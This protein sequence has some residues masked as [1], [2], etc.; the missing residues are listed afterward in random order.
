[1]KSS[2]SLKQGKCVALFIQV[3][4]THVDWAPS[5]DEI[6]SR[7]NITPNV[8]PRVFTSASRFK[9]IQDVP[10]SWCHVQQNNRTVNHLSDY[11]LSL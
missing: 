11:F 10:T 7:T 5:Q 1:M 9:N 8:G 6:L 4:G 2:L 3:T